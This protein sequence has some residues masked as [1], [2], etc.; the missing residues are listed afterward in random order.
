VNGFAGRGG[1]FAALA[2][3]PLLAAPALLASG[4]RLAPETL[5]TA[6]VGCA[7]LAALALS[8]RPRARALLAGL[9]ALVVTL[10]L[11]G[12]GRA[13]LDRRLRSTE[14]YGHR[15]V[16]LAR[17]Y[18]PEGAG[19]YLLSRAGG[20]PFRFFGYE[21]GLGGAARQYREDWMDPRA[22]RVLVNNGATALGLED[23]QGYNPVHIRRYDELMEA[24]NGRRQG[25]H[26]SYVFPAGL[27]SPLLDLLNVRYI[28]SPLDAPSPRSTLAGL[29]RTLRTVYSDAGVRVLE[30][31]TA[32]PRAWLVHEARRVSPG[33]APELLAE[34]AVNPRRVALLEAPP[35]RLSR[36]P[37]PSLDRAEVV[38][39]SADRLVVRT[40][41]AAPALLV[42]SEPYDPA[43]KA[44]V[45][46][47]DAPVLV[48]DHALRAVAAPAGERVVELRYDS[49][50]LNA[51]V[52]V[53]GASYL[54]L[55]ALCGLALWR[56]VRA[57]GGAPVGPAQRRRR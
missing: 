41:S 27:R 51:G 1:R 39:R 56:R 52:A 29:H 38:E 10:D 11:L 16:D 54:L 57:G 7:L 13:A 33:E 28:V 37:R 50:A 14:W 21:P 8:P 46:G 35:P 55:A 9:L 31:R 12:V 19:E 15:R 49:W 26:Q 5:A 17:R 48:A 24:L 53:S 25:Y 40:R 22:D 18:A 32:L 36:P 30:R 20:P 43:W 6:A 42:L 23:I 4:V 45:D 34:G 47:S 3:L 44:R 2:A